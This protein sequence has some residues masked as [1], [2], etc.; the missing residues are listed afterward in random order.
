MRAAARDRGWGG[1]LCSP[2]SGLWPCKFLPHGGLSPL[3]V[4]ESII[5]GGA[6]ISGEGRLSFPWGWGPSSMWGSA[7]LGSSPQSTWVCPSRLHHGLHTATHRPPCWPRSCRIRRW[8]GDPCRNSAFGGKIVSWN[9]C[10]EPQPS[11]SWPHT[12]GAPG[13]CRM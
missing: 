10:P 13:H 6:A 11:H 1:G 3:R 8:P 2:G 12:G 5:L 4:P 7:A 9:Y